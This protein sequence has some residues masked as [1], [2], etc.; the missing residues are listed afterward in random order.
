MTQP[1]A[2]QYDAGDERQALVRAEHVRFR[3]LATRPMASDASTRPAPTPSF[4]QLSLAFGR[5]V[6]G[7]H[8]AL[9]TADLIADALEEAHEHQNQC[10]PVA[11][12]I[13]GGDQADLRRP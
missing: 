2:E 12:L 9:A 1:N 10:G 8:T 3:Q 11:D 5:T 13:I 4:G 7:D 6:N